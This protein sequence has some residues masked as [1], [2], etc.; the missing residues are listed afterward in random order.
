MA[1]QVYKNHAQDY[2]AFVTKSSSAAEIL[3]FSLAQNTL[4]PIA[5]RLDLT[6]GSK[7]NV[8]DMIVNA[9]GLTYSPGADANVIPTKIGVI[10]NKPVLF[11]KRKNKDTYVLKTSMSVTSRKVSVDVECHVFHIHIAKSRDNDNVEVTVHGVTNTGN[12]YRACLKNGLNINQPVSMSKI[13]L[14]TETVVV[15]KSKVGTVLW[16]FI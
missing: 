11:V 8:P 5:H 4:N 1:W 10:P 16:Q 3:A 13:K 6:T 15:P 7:S 12:W 14:L 2:A 9:I